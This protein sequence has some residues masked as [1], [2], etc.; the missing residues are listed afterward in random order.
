MDELAL[1]RAG[2]AAPPVDLIA[3][4]RARLFSKRRARR[5]VLVA[6][7]AVACVLGGAGALAATGVLGDGLLAGP[8]APPENDAALR[9][10]FPPFRIGHATQLAE[11][12]GR[13]LFG[14]RTAKG[15]YCFSATSPTDPKGEGGHCLSAAGNRR[16]AAGESVSFSMSGWSVGGYA[17]GAAEVRLTGAGIDETLPVG[18]KGWWLGVAEVPVEKLMDLREDTSVVATRLAPDGDVM[19]T[20]PAIHIHTAGSG[21]VQFWSGDG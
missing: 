7:V 14:A 6:A 9:N 15:G 4:E 16:L 5:R 13:T 19:S 8:A 17:P 1:F 10:L 12:Q 21:V 3:R 18:E 11:H 2:V 20:G